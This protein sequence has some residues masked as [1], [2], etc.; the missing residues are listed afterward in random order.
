M[1]D[2][3]LLGPPGSGKS[4]QAARLADEVGA[5]HV[6]PG[7]LLREIAA[8]DSS[9]GRRVSRAMAAGGLVPDELAHDVVRRRVESV[10]AGR[11]VVYDGYPRT[12]AQA[13]ALRD[14]HAELGRPPPAL[15]RLDL[16][17]EEQ[18]SRLRLRRES[19]GRDDD[20]EETVGKR[21]EAYDRETAPTLDALAGW[22][23]VTEIDA[24][25][26]AEDVTGELLAAIRS[27]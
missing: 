15:V 1:R 14:L 11:P 22:A 24:G 19:E 3:I 16:P 17:H 18:R 8:D 6:S 21:L 10:P 5:E 26:P 27:E 2:V 20:A 9:L 12:A 13:E 23:G 4:T 25:R 7:A